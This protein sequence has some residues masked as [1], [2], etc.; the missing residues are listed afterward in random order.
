MFED[1]VKYNFET[2]LNHILVC[3][4]RFQRIN[5]AKDFVNSEEGTLCLMLLLHVCNPL[6]K[7]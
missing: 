4:K 3:E 2:I 1:E 6:P 7:T 5:E